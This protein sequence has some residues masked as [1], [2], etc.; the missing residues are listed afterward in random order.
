M[1]IVK[2]YKYLYYTTLYFHPYVSV[3][4][5]DCMIYYKMYDKRYVFDGIIVDAKTQFYYTACHDK[6]VTSRSS[7]ILF[8]G[9]SKPT[10]CDKK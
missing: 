3:W 7:K 5:C 4:L 2:N 8:Y 1:Q 9:A 6:I 10:L